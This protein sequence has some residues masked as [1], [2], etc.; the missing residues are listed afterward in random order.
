MYSQEQ[1]IAIRSV[2]DQFYHHNPDGVVVLW[3]ATATGKT[4]LSVSL[5]D[6]FP[7]EVISSDSR[8][9]FR[10]MD[11]WT[12]KVSSVIRSQLP[13]HL[14]DIVDPDMTYTAGQW[15]HDAVMGVDD[16]Q[17][18]WK[19][20]WIVG[21]TGLYIDTVYKNFSMPSVEPDLLLRKQLEERESLSPWSL[22]DELLSCDPTEAKKLDPRSLRYIIRAL[23]IYYKSWY[24]KSSYTERRTPQW[25]LL[26]LG[27]WRDK[28][29][30]NKLIDQRVDHMLES[31]LIDETQW[32]LEQWYSPT[33]QSMQ[34]IWYKQTVSYLYEHCDLDRLAG[35]I[36]QATYHLAKKQRS[37]FRR[38]LED[39]NLGYDK[40]SYHTI[41]LS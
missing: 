13:H 40:V 2:I 22:W 38:Y 24:P 4:S 28:H 33:L 32:L 29:D 1:L 26:L 17:S 36:K 27:L 25:P 23:E 15:N 18:R 6:Y 8:Q 11:I 34:G 21:G 20:P 10:Y 39:S 16:I 35:E 5:S 14:I 7:L 30:T 41:Y 19:L 31:W 37:W 12:D 9:V 3:W